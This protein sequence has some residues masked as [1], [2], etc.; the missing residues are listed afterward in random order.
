MTMPLTRYVLRYFYSG[1][2][3]FSHLQYRIDIKQGGVSPVEVRPYVLGTPIDPPSNVL[4]PYPL[5]ISAKEK[6]VY[7]LPRESFNLGG[8]LLNPMMLAM[9]LCGVLVLAMPYIMVSRSGCSL[10]QLEFTEFEMK[11][12]KTWIPVCLK[13]SKRSKADWAGP[14]IKETQILGLFGCPLCLKII[15]YQMNVQH[16]CILL[17]SR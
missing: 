13:N 3:K 11:C 12:R 4:L 10:S 16:I 1:L 17:F 2:N 5:S 9:I 15:S 8:M 14:V 6:F 7:F